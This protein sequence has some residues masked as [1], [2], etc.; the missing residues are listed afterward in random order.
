MFNWKFNILA[1]LCCGKVYC[2]YY[3]VCSAYYVINV[4]G[5]SK[6]W[7][8][9]KLLSWPQIK[10]VFVKTTFIVKGSVCYF[11]SNKYKPNNSQNKKMK[12]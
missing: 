10:L 5:V 4:Q 3:I 8:N 7:I 1:L 11:M 2:K 12:N 9:F 6:K